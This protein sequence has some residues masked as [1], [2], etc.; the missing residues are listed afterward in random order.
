MEVKILFLIVIQ[1]FVIFLVMQIL[2]NSFQDKEK[3]TEEVDKLYLAYIMHKI[4]VEK[5]KEID[6]IDIEDIK[7]YQEENNDE[8]MKVYE[9]IL[10][11]RSQWIR[12]KTLFLIFMGF[13]LSTYIIFA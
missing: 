2:K 1:L 12:L 5:K 11:G 8:L 13:L 4:K 7:K 3:I 9:S 10:I 6:D